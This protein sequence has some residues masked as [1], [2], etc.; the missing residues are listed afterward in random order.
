MKHTESQKP[1][2][3]IR[4]KFVPIGVAIG[5]VALIV[6]ISLMFTQCTG[7]RPH[8]NE[9]TIPVTVLEVD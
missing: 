1:E 2:S 8:I 3:L 9:T 7:E 5:E 6:G 4:D